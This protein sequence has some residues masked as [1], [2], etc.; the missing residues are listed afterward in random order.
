MLQWGDFDSEREFLEYCAARR[1]WAKR[2]EDTPSGGMT[3]AQW[4]R[5][6]F[7]RELDVAAAEF[8]AKLDP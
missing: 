7:G 1:I 5:Q 2:D 3:W 4:F 6:M 8:K